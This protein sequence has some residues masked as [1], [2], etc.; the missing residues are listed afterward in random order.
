MPFY[1]DILE[2]LTAEV[3]GGTGNVVARG[4]M[5]PQAF[6]PLEEAL[7][8]D[9]ARQANITDAELSNELGQ[10]VIAR[11]PLNW[12]TTHALANLLEKKIPMLGK[13]GV[14]FVSQ[15]DSYLTRP[16]IRAAVDDIVKPTLGKGST[17]IISHSLGTIVCYVLLRTKINQLIVPLFVTLGS[18]L[19]IET[20]KGYLKPPALAVPPGVALWL[21]GTDP[22]DYVALVP[23]LGE[24]TFCTGIVNHAGIHNR[25]DDA[26]SIEDYLSDFAVA[27]RIHTALA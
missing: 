15:V 27:Q 3:R 12:E 11:S 19:G 21:N 16:H 26:H 5:G 20:V 2:K 23:S 4:A 10:N 6:T 8:R 13:V 1:G 24:E 9:M 7:I 18:P 22:R 14:G 17:V 25:R